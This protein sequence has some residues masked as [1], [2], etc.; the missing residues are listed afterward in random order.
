MKRIRREVLKQ[1]KMVDFA[2]RRRDVIGEIVAYN[3]FKQM[4][5]DAIFKLNELMGT[6]PSLKDSPGLLSIAL[7]EKEKLEKIAWGR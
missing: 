6:I 3:A 4:V 7:C 1:F 5:S 2:E